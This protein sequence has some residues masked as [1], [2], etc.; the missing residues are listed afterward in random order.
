LAD[1]GIQGESGSGRRLGQG[2]SRRAV[3]VCILPGHRDRSCLQ[4]GSSVVLL[5]IG[6]V[7]AVVSLEDD[8]GEYQYWYGHVISESLKRSPG[9]EER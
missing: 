6:A 9:Q 5:C 2:G 4:S 3:R 1:F 7:T 8:E